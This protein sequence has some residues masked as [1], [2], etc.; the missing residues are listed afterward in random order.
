M[1]A[2]RSRELQWWDRCR[3]GLLVHTSASAVPAWAPIGQYAE[4]Y[5]AHLE[6]GVRDVLLHPSPMVETV[7]HHQAR[8]SHVDRFDDFVEL[9]TF[10]EFDASEWAQLA[11][12]AG[13]SYTVMVAKH[14]DGLCWWDA[15]GTDHTA[16]E[17]GP[18]RNV[19]G[20]Y[21]RAARAAGLEFGTYYSLLDWVDPRYPSCSY[22]DGVVHPQ[23]LD[24]V[25][26]Y[27]SR[28]LWGDGHWGG[29]G[30]HWRSDELIAAAR[31]V[32][33]SLIVNDRWWSE[34]PGVRSY[35]YRLP[36]GIVDG[37]WEM[38]RGI[39]GSFGFNRA[40][41]DEHLLDA[42]GIVALLTEVLAKGGHLLLSVGPDAQGRFPTEHADR[43]RAAGAWVTAHR[44]LV[45]RAR[46][47]S[48]WG[49]EH[50]RY[51]E[52]DGRLHAVDVSGHGRFGALGR[53]AGRVTTVV[54]VEP[55]GGV[56]AVD[57]E[58]TA[59]RLALLP[60]S[61]D[62]HRT[63]GGS[64]PGGV[65]ASVY[66]IE[67]E[68][69]EPAPV[70]LFA[71]EPPAPIE[72]A[73]VIAAA[74]GD[75][76][77]QLGDGVYVGPA[78]VPP[79]V[80]IRGLGPDRTVI[81]GVESLAVV[82]GEGARV[83]HCTLRGGGE[84][85]IWLPK[86]VVQLGG[87]GAALLGCHVDGHVTVAASD[88][89]ITSCVLTGLVAAGVDRVSLLRSTLRGMQWDCAVDIQS[90]A[91]HVVE[92]CDIA[93]VLE[94]VR[95][96]STICVAVR[97]NRIRARWWGVRAVDSEAPLIAANAI[98]RTM[99]AVDV[100]GGTLAEVTG[101]AVADGDSGCVVQHGAADVTV[102]GN[103]WERTRVGLLAWD[104]GALRQ[105]DNT[106]VDLLEP[107]DAVVVGP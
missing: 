33:P 47:W 52:L 99:R 67:I 2:P 25:E 107:D 62:H 42:D 10:D 101:N 5:R 95:V 4:W 93:D 59:D 90:G 15:P 26:R 13:M 83:E 14:H 11:I 80:T 12:D 18:R 69:P 85:I 51:L 98:S 36:P 21:A 71:V 6:G 23:V 41:R 39:G 91:G 79:G 78:Q 58:Q 53:S 97:G 100:D 19:L 38:R 37:P 77:V 92:T 9:L 66:R 106:M 96:T 89:R 8:W 32:D 31:T 73:S 87:A 34:G 49:D 20:E 54:R 27:G 61:R 43:L 1:A 74:A 82:L 45:E 105:H 40:E 55:G 60:R 81:D 16:V 86:P 103:R 64:Q 76:I 68:P 102:A 35:E 29:G 30:S 84:R 44:R 70:E 50:C 22:V 56:T 72:L 75:R 48:A 88:C 17:L 24:L 7:A 28:M 94:G 65:R 63:T 3:F 104:A 57:F 46:P